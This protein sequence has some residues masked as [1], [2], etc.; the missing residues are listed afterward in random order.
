MCRKNILAFD[1]AQIHASIVPESSVQIRKVVVRFASLKTS[2]VAHRLLS[3]V[4][5][6]ASLGDRKSWFRFFYGE[7]QAHKKSQGLEAWEKICYKKFPTPENER[8]TIENQPWMKMYLLLKMVLFQPAMSL[9]GGVIHARHQGGEDA[10]FFVCLRG[11]AMSHHGW[12]LKDQWKDYLNSNQQGL[13]STFQLFPVI[14]LLSCF[15]S[16]HPTV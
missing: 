16:L 8:M 2:R 6:R 5:G 9:F 13:S 11:R 15:T 1:Y 12:L 3:F 14:S 4:S 7:Y 10:S